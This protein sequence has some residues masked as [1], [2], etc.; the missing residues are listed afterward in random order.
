VE[1]DAHGWHDH[2]GSWSAATE[3]EVFDRALACIDDL[4]RE[5]LVVAT[6]FLF[7]RPMWSRAVRVERLRRPR[8]GRVEIRSWA[9]SRDA[10]LP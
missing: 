2:F 7:G 5:R 3:G 8:F 10:T 6:R 4:L 9:G 1:F